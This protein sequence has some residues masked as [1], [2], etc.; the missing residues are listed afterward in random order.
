MGYTVRTR[1]RTRASPTAG[2]LQPSP[3]SA[4]AFDLLMRMLCWTCN[5]HMPGLL[6]CCG[7]GREGRGGVGCGVLDQDASR[8]NPTVGKRREVALAAAAGLASRHA[9]T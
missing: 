1:A 6:L 2:R 5:V 9:C 4:A 3:S 7:G 8:L